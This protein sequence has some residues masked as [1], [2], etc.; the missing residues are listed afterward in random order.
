[1]IFFNLILDYLIIHLYTS[2]IRTNVIRFIQ[3]IGRDRLKQTFQI[4]DWNLN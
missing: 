4:S 3:S 1:M 2:L